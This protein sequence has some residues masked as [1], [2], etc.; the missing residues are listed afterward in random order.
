MDG[1]GR[2]DRDL[3]VLIFADLG[4][5]DV[6]G[7]RLSRGRTHRRVA[8]SDHAGD[9]LFVSLVLTA[10]IH[11]LWIAFFGTDTILT[12]PIERA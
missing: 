6:A 10:V 9:R 12:L 2:S 4:C 5:D 11:L 7:G 3:L 8:D 1:L